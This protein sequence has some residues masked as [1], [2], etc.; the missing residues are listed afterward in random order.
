M[1]KPSKFMIKRAKRTKIGRLAC[2]LL[3]DQ[4]G[5]V[6]MEY[7]VLGVLLVAAVVGAVVYFGKG[8][9]GG[10]HIMTDAITDPGKAETTRT[11]E[12]GN[13]ATEL[14]DAQ[15]HQNEMTGKGK[16]N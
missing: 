16:K 4:S 12:I 14:S 6:L 10:F 3:G 2:R 8:L 9:T 1:R 7:V 11:T 15:R 5:A 13:N